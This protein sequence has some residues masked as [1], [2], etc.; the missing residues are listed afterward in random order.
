MKRLNINPLAG[1]NLQSLKPQTSGLALSEVRYVA[2]A[3]LVTNSLN[4][5]FPEEKARY[6]EE[7]EED[8]RERGV[9]VPLIA[10]R[11]GTLL[12]GHN[13]LR[14]ALKLNLPK[15]PVQYVEAPLTEQEEIR[16][17]I[18]DNLFRRQL[19]NEDKI[20]L[21]EHL[22]E[23]FTERIAMRHEVT[24]T[25]WVDNVHPSGSPLTATIIA[26]DTGQSAAAV[27]KQ[28]QRYE[29]QSRRESQQNRRTQEEVAVMSSAK[30]E[31]MMRARERE[32]DRALKSA[33]EEIA[34]QLQ[35]TDVSG[36]WRRTAMQR[37]LRSMEKTQMLLPA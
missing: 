22:Y 35:R 14:V 23:N 8:V 2:P 16:F 30:S 6:F 27:Q 36:D 24:T 7:L 11:D 13:R 17:V 1:A 20:R 15:I 21:Y 3:T 33:V 28:L 37:V 5:I 32:A 29:A 4:S 25:S 19:S 34:M 9:I 31:E 26:R 12:A 18:A 10:K